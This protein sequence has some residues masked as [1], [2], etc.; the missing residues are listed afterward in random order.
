MVAEEIRKLAENAG[1]QA[2]QIEDLIKQLESEAGRIADV[3]RSMQADAGG[4]SSDL[5][6]ILDALEQIQS[7]VRE[8]QERSDAIFQDA[9]AQVGAAELMV[10]DVESV[11]GVAN[12][13]AKA[14]DGMQRALGEQT[15]RMERIASQAGGLSGMAT[16]LGEVARRF[17][18]R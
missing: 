4:G 15:E 18:T 3:M 2:V 11:A 8:V 5:D 13:N 17:R 1:D 6:R 16:E 14:T 10:R 12:E 7:A 9:D